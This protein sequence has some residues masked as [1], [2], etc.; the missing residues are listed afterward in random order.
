MVNILILQSVKNLRL[1]DKS[2]VDVVYSVKLEQVH[3]LL[4]FI[5]SLNLSIL[6][7]L[8]YKF[9]FSN[10]FSAIMISIIF[11]TERMSSEVYSLAF[12][13]LKV[14]YFLE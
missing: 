5:L 7:M 6:L 14:V 12:L 1:F 3:R 13:C 8:S 9:F 11:N 4:L 10:I 2:I